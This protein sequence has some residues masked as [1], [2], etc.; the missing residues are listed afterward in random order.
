MSKVY[1]KAHSRDNGQEK[2]EFGLN[3]IRITEMSGGCALVKGSWSYKDIRKLTLRNVDTPDLSFTINRLKKG[4]GVNKKIHPEQEQI[5]TLY[6]ASHKIKNA[7]IAKRTDIKKPNLYSVLQLVHSLYDPN[8]D[9]EWSRQS[10]LTFL[11]HYNNYH[12]LDYETTK[13]AE[14]I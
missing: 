12:D 8:I 1:Q 13:T 14:R 10:F 7:E 3:Q 9:D 5:F 4:V 11:D 6:F 2:V